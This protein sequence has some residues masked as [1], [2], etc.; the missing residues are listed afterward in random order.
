MNLFVETMIIS[1]TMFFLCLVPLVSLTAQKYSRYFFLAGTGA[2]AGLLVFDLFPDV[3]SMGGRSSLLTIAGVWICYSLLHIFHIGHHHHGEEAHHDESK[4][5]SL[6]TLK[7]PTGVSLVFAASMMAHCLSSGMFLALSAAPGDNFHRTVFLALL[8]HKCYEALTFSTVVFQN[9]KARAHSIIL[10]VLYVLS[11]PAGV[12][13]VFA[14]KQYITQGVALI[15]TSFAIGTL[16]GCLIFD[17]LLPSLKQLKK[18]HRDLG[19]IVAGLLITQLVMK[20]V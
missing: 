16:L 15:A 7:E 4:D 6:E 12:V 5:D 19:W 18:Q 3:I 1:G 2:L 8:A 13:A 10:I 9:Q 20:L 14:A 17:F 11:L